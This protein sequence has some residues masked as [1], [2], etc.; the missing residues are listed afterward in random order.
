MGCDWLWDESMD[1]HIVFNNILLSWT[2]QYHMNILFL[3]LKKKQQQQQK[4]LWVLK[5]KTICTGRCWPVT[6]FLVTFGVLGW[7]KSLTKKILKI[8]ICFIS[9]WLGV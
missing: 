7:E 3:Y 6:M 1:F 8:K 2:F 9:L 4:S 5:E